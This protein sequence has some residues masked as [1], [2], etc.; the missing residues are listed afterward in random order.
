[1]GNKAGRDHWKSSSPASLLNNVLLGIL[2]TQFT[3]HFYQE[4]VLRYFKYL[5][6]CL[7]S[8]FFSLP[9]G[10]GVKMPTLSRS[11]LMRFSSATSKSFRYLVFLTIHPTLVF[12][13]SGVVIRN[14]NLFCLQWICML[15]WHD[16]SP[17]GAF[18]LTVTLSR[19]YIYSLSWRFLTSSQVNF[20]FV[21]VKCDEFNHEHSRK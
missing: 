11:G 6:H 15:E 14:D 1:M 20:H 3:D 21:E 7:C 5:L 9:A 2:T 17:G 12:K 19:V 10:V 8:D 16:K 13:L 4:I 18:I